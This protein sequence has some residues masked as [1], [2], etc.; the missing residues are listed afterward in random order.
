MKEAECNLSLDELLKFEGVM[1]VGISVQRK[2]GG[3]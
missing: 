1:A 2:A 3:L